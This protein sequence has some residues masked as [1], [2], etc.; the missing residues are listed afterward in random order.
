M[1]SLSQNIKLFKYR[2]TPSVSLFMK[3]FTEIE[4]IQSRYSFKI[5]KNHKAYTY[6]KINFIFSTLCNENFELK[7]IK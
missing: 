2:F 4:K 3:I 1:I 6:K 7:L 5:K